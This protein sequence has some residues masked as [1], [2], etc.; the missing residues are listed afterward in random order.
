MYDEYFFYE[1][2]IK[3]LYFH[4]H[5]S[6]INILFNIMYQQ[7]TDE[8]KQNFNNP[9]NKLLT[10]LEKIQLFNNMYIEFLKNQREARISLET[11][12]E[13]TNNG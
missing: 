13:K 3:R 11:Y 5:L 2:D 7:Q 12:K 4:Q 6:H 8:W 1:I 9:N 10:L